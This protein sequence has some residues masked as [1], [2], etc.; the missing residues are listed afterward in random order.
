V[1]CCEH[2]PFRLAHHHLCLS[3]FP[4]HNAARA[5]AVSCPAWPLAAVCLVLKTI[6]LAGLAGA[7]LTGDAAVQRQGLGRLR[8]LMTVH[9]LGL[10]DEL[11]RNVVSCGVVGPLVAL[12]SPE[13]GTNAREAPRHTCRVHTGAA[14]MQRGCCATDSRLQTTSSC[15]APQ[16]RCLLVCNARSGA[17]RRL[18]GDAAAAGVRR[19]SRGPSAGD[20]C[21]CVCCRVAQARQLA[22]CAA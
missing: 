3:V 22:R 6:M 5:A 15:F 2:V 4:T 16:T 9:R 21:C 1:A 18:R 10:G 19:D 12:C 14:S 11:A 7:L 13:A 8:L 20:K 17:A